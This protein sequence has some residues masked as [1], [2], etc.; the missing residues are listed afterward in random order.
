MQ[1][2]IS[3]V[4][5][6]QEQEKQQI[7]EKLDDPSIKCWNDVQL[8]GTLPFEKNLGCD[9]PV[10]CHVSIVAIDFKESYGIQDQFWNTRTEDIKSNPRW[11]TTLF[12]KRYF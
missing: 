3:V 2:S 7:W 10:G 12:E 1:K 8:V 4:E 9:D 5:V 11:C 6:I